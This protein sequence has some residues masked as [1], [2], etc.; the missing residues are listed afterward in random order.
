MDEK[1][2]ALERLVTLDDFGRGSILYQLA[3]RCGVTPALELARISEEIGN[4]EGKNYK[5]YIPSYR[6]ILKKAA[7][8]TQ[9]MLTEVLRGKMP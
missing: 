3:E 7:G 8:S 6:S 4:R 2:K 5:H 9:K 1:A